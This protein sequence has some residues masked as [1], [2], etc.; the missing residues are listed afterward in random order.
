[1]IVDSHCHVSP[2]WYEPAESLLFQM[3]RNGV[4]RAVLIQMMGQ[5]D[6]SYQFDCLRRFPGRFASVVIVDTDRPDAPEAL[7]RLAEVGASGVRFRPGTRSPG[8]DPLAAWRAAARL[9]LAVSCLGTAAEFA[10]GE[11]A[12]LIGSLPELPI[13]VEHL[14]GVG[15]PGGEPLPPETVQGVFGLARFANVSIKVP[16]LGEFCRRALPVAGPFPFVE[17]VPPYL[18]MA[19]EA[20]GPRRMLWGSDYPPVSAREGYRNALRLAMEQFADR[21]EA[22][23]DLIFGGTALSL[24][25]FRT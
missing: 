14:G 2:L 16:G 8:E 23:R 1:L 13:V 15:R 22:E 9:G 19:Y 10:A 6:N 18:R 4:E 20:F 25:P 3:D 24:F 7:A 21:S 17:P 12:Q 5:A 11:F